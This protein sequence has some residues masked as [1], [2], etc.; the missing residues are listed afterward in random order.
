[1]KKFLLVD[2]SHLYHRAKHSV[3][4]NDYDKAGFCLHLIFSCLGKVWRKY[5]SD[6][7]VFA[8]D[9][10]QYWRREL[11]SPYKK[12]RIEKAAKRSQE[13]KEEDDYF[14]E[15]FE[16]FKKFV[17]E[18]TNCTVLYH[19]KLEAD[20]NIAGWVQSHPNDEHIIVS[21]DKDFEQL[22]SSNVSLYDG[23]K[24]HLNTLTGVYD[25]RGHQVTDKFGTVLIPNP[26]LSL[27]EKEVKGCTTDNIFS[28]SPGIRIKSSKNKV[29]LME[30]FEDRNKKGFAWSAVMMNRWVDHN[31]IEHRTLDDYTRNVTLVDLKK[32]PE[33]IK[34]I[35]NETISSAIQKPHVPMVGIHFMKFCSKYELV[36][37]G[38]MNK[39][40][41]EML[42]KPYGTL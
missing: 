31:N 15:V 30:A 13:E 32:Q 33:E 2:A 35:M 28:S 8:F 23:I 39:F 25:E 9:G 40:Y 1:M 20:D 10:N 19:P 5:K 36:K 18:K 26:E 21:G 3:K 41:G 34:K 22:I 6:H 37:L 24:D 38:E 17:T 27:F 7:I 11:Y 14:F 12:Q 29:G 42:N 16:V 4:G